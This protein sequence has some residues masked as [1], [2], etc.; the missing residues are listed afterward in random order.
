MRFLFPGSGSIVKSKVSVTMTLWGA[1]AV[2]LPR[3][4][5]SVTKVGADYRAQVR[6]AGESFSGNGGSAVVFLDDGR[7]VQAG[8]RDARH[9][10]PVRPGGVP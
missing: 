9:G 8:T 6:A 3:I 1:E 2:P 4:D 5:M 7:G 10:P